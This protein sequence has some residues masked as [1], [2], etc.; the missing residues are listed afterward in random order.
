MVKQKLASLLLITILGFGLLTLA[1]FWLSNSL[2][3]PRAVPHDIAVAL[4]GEIT[5][6]FTRVVTIPGTPSPNVAPV[7]PDKRNINQVFTNGIVSI[8]ASDDYFLID[9]TRVSVIEVI[10]DSRCPATVNCI[11]PGT[12]KLNLSLI[13]MTN[14]RGIETYQTIELDKPFFINNMQLE[15]IEVI[16]PLISEQA[17]NFSDYRFTFRLI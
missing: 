12:V 13:S 16:P 14:N 6:E 1:I 15:L 11:W 9:N 10:E 7:T 2:G 4:P 8:A 5:E 17:I 3:L